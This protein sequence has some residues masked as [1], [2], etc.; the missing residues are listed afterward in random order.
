MEM[1]D[2]VKA[3]LLFKEEKGLT[4]ESLGEIKDNG[5]YIDDNGFNMGSIEDFL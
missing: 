1:E 5:E 3:L 4:P 2:W